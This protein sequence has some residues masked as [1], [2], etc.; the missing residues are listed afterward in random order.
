MRKVAYWAALFAALL[1]LCAR[2]ALAG[3]PPAGASVTFGTGTKKWAPWV[4]TAPPVWVWHHTDDWFGVTAT[5]NSA[6]YG[7]SRSAAIYVIYTYYSATGNVLYANSQVLISTPA[8]KMF[9]GTNSDPFTIN[10]ATPESFVNQDVHRPT[11]WRYLDYEYRV[12]VKIGYE[13]PFPDQSWIVDNNWYTGWRSAQNSL[14][15]HTTQAF[16]ADSTPWN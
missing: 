9:T 5:E 7:V 4:D 16:T 8:D 3:T 12:Y 1:W 2:P 11:G 15:D 13:T 10:T 6:G 14:W